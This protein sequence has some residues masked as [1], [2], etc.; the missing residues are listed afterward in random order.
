[1]EINNSV[2]YKTYSDSLQDIDMGLDVNNTDSIM[3]LLRNSIYSNPIESFVREIYSNAVDAHLRDN[4]TT[5]I[6][7]SLIEDSQT[8]QYYFM[9]RDYGSSMTVEDF[10]NIYSKMGNSTK[11]KS[12]KELGGFGIGCK[13]PLA[14][15]NQF[16]IDTWTEEESKFIHRE[17][18]QYIDSSQIGKISLLKE[19]TF[20]GKTG[21]QI[22]IPIKFKDYHNITN[23][24][25]KYLSYS[26]VPFVV[27]GFKFEDK[28]PELNVVGEDWGLSDVYQSSFYFSAERKSTIVIAGIP[29][30][31]DK[32]VLHDKFKSNDFTTL[33]KSEINPKSKSIK[34]NLELFKSFLESSNYLQYILLANV[35]DLDL[36]ASREDLQYTDRTL[37]F[38]Y[39]KLFKMFQGFCDHLLI[40]YVY[41]PS[42]IE[43]CK[44]FSLRCCPTIKENIISKIRWAKENLPF[45]EKPFLFK[46][47]WSSEL[48]KYEI[49]YQGYHPNV[50]KV[51]SSS[52]ISK[53]NFF[54]EPTK[55]VFVL[56]DTDYVNYTKFIKDYVLRIKNE[57]TAVL[58]VEPEDF[59][60]LCGWVTDSVDFT[61]LSKIVKEY[62]D[63]H[64]ANNTKSKKKRDA[65]VFNAYRYVGYEER[66]RAEDYGKFFT[67]D[68]APS[69]PEEEHYYVLADEMSDLKNHGITLGSTYSYS[70]LE[71]MN[72]YLKY[73]NINYNKVWYINKPSKHFSKDNWF[74]LAEVIKGDYKAI[75]KSELKDYTYKLTLSLAIPKVA[76]LFKVLTCDKENTT[77]RY[78]KLFKHYKELCSYVENN[79]PDFHHLA[80][81]TD[82][83]YRNLF[84]KDCYKN[85]QF[86]NRLSKTNKVLLAYKEFMEDYPLL[87]NVGVYTNAEDLVNYKTYIKAMGLYLKD[88]NKNVTFNT[89]QE[90]D[91]NS[92]FKNMLDYFNS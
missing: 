90:G 84:T 43:A 7:V 39:K 71:C 9:V 82:E 34:H 73:K 18:V 25:N 78:S 30:K 4:I 60:N 72:K 85:D 46:D 64:S 27:K 23:Y 20:T 41:N 58:V 32:K 49:S 54:K 42:Y 80:I 63:W 21:T 87:N 44:N 13:S 83:V 53:I 81:F 77:S 75:N 12:N 65:S 3:A 48:K 2:K 67:P 79:M 15:T 92:E 69:D 14:Y 35:G 76:P 6:E 88:D 16:F 33:I 38:L 8:N 89:N 28:R 5:P 59:P 10:K 51:L 36:S 57:D 50:K 55:Y 24:I 91:T 56:Q 68:K 61:K 1:M 47:G 62:K 66:S 40:D 17:W 45:I 19:G 52:L 26:I 29:Y 37:Y 74:S 11:N 31:I 86:F 70:F 22:K